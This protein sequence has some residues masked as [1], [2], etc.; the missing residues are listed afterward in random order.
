MPKIMPPDCRPTSCVNF[1]HL[2]CMIE[3]VHTLIIKSE[4]EENKKKKVNKSVTNPPVCSNIAARNLL[5]VSNYYHMNTNSMATATS[6]R[7]KERKL[8]LSAKNKLFIWLFLPC[9][10]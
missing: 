2:I 8:L 10:P 7:A 3:T 5:S 4:I 9:K 6:H 1:G